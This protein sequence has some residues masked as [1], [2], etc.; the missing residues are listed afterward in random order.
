VGGIMK[1]YDKTKRKPTAL[2]VG[3]VGKLFFAK[4]WEFIFG[5]D[6]RRWFPEKWDLSEV[7][8]WKEYGK[9]EGF[10]RYYK[11]SDRYLKFV[12]GV[13]IKFYENT[14]KVKYIVGYTRTGICSIG[15][16]KNRLMG[17]VHDK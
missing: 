7:F 2:V 5:Y 9:N 1:Y 12:N 15:V 4:L 8:I 6:H 14:F 13:D 3:A 10:V 11:S 17:L 16:N